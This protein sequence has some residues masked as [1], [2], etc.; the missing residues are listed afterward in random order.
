MRTSHVLQRIAQGEIG[1]RGI[2]QY[3]VGLKG[4]EHLGKCIAA[5]HPLRNKVHASLAQRL[6]HQLGI[7]QYIIEN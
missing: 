6:L 4:F 5:I 3:D 1:W 7:N 2:Y